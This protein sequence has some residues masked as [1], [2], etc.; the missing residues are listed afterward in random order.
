MKKFRGKRRYFH[1]LR[2][3]EL[4]ENQGIDFGEDDW[5]DY[6]HTHL[7]WFG[8]GNTS[9]KMRKQHI[10]SF[11]KL[12]A[13]LEVE[14]EQRGKPYQLWLQLSTNDAGEDAVYIHT[15]NPNADNFPYIYTGPTKKIEQ[16]PNFLE[17]IIDEQAYEIICYE[18]EANELYEQEADVNYIV[19]R[20][21]DNS[22]YL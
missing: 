19:K 1:N 18:V 2:K 11:L 9:L 3:A 22:L 10:Q 12:M 4:V 17:G 20:I 7:D 21:H 6:W 13:N 8:Y 15:E 16:L 14:L 5:F